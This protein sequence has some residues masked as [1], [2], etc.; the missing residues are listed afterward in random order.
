MGTCGFTCAHNNKN[1]CF[2]STLICIST[3]FPCK[4]YVLADI[5]KTTAWYC[6]S[7]LAHCNTY[8]H[9]NECDWMTRR[10]S[11]MTKMYI[12]TAVTC[13]QKYKIIALSTGK[14]YLQ[15]NYIIL[16]GEKTFN[17]IYLHEIHNIS[18]MNKLTHIKSN[19][20]WK[21]FCCFNQNFS[22]QTIESNKKHL[23]NNAYSFGNIL[24]IAKKISKWYLC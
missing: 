13:N 4:C 8:H 24:S 12:F 1:G 18:P 22:Q 3:V 5:K 10:V 20:R 23:I 16:K 17:V 14:S 11:F 6:I 19:V 15:L 21:T 7:C 9:L 2:V